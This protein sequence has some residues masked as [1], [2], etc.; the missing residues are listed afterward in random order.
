MSLL[1][2]SETKQIAHGGLT[3]TIALTRDTTAN[4]INTKA[5]ASKTGSGMQSHQASDGIEHRVG[6]GAVAMT[7]NTIKLTFG[8]STSRSRRISSAWFHR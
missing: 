4:I 1:K 8:P 7:P 3:E 2:S 5:I 6:D